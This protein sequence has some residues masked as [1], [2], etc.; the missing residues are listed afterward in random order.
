MTAFDV[1]KE[2]IA[3]KLHFTKLQY[4][5]FKYFGKTKETIISFNKRPDAYFFEYFAKNGGSKEI[6]KMKLVL[7]FM[8]Y[9][10][11]YIKDVVNEY[12]KPDNIYIKW[13]AYIDGL[14]YTFFKELSNLKDICIVEKLT[15]SEMIDY[16]HGKVPGFFRAYL[17]KNIT[18]ETF[19]ILD[20]L[21]FFTNKM[22]GDFVWENEKKFLLKYYPFVYEYIK[23]YLGKEEIKN[24]VLNTFRILI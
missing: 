10:N 19:F 20:S 15:F 12:R 23:S 24:K 7:F 4:D 18:P 3:I 5:Y 21:F 13:K 16:Y 11:L 22:R 14:D 9:K 1:Y 8:E 2:Y 6:L 17:D